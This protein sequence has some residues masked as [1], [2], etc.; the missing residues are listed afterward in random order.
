MKKFFSI[1]ML[2]VVAAGLAFAIGNNDDVQK[3]VYSGNGNENVGVCVNEFA[4]LRQLPENKNMKMQATPKTAEVTDWTEWTAYA[5]QD[6]PKGVYTYTAFF[7]GDD[8]LNIYVRESA[9]VPTTKQFKLEKWGMGIDLLINYDET[10]GQCRVPLQNI[11]YYHTTYKDSIYIGDF[12]YMISE[13]Y[14]DTYPCSYD[15]ETGLF[16]LNTFYTMKSYIGKGSGWYNSSKPETFKMSGDYVDY[17][18][19]AP[20]TLDINDTENLPEGAD[21]VGKFIIADAG[22]DIAYYRL[23]AFDAFE[24]D[25]EACKES[26]AVTFPTQFAP[27]DTATVTVTGTQ[28]VIYFVAYAYDSN[29][30]IVATTMTSSQLENN[31]D[32]E[33]V[34]VR[35]YRDD[36]LGPAYFNIST[37]EV[38]DVE[39][40][41]NIYYPSCYRLKNPYGSQTSFGANY[42]Q[43]ENAYMYFTIDSE[44][45]AVKL[46]KNIYTQDLGIDVMAKAYGLESSAPIS[47][48]GNS[49]SDGTFDGYAISWPVKGIIYG[50]GSSGYYGNTNGLERIVINFRETEVTAPVGVNVEE[51][52]KI[53]TNNSLNTPQFESLTPEVA[54]VDEKGNV[55]GVAAGTAQIKVTQEAILEYETLD[56]VLN[57]EVTKADYDIATYVFND[58]TALVALGIELPDSAAGASLN[59]K[60]LTVGDVSISFDKGEATTDPRIWHGASYDLRIYKKNSFTVSVPE[61]KK[62]VGIDVVGTKVSLLSTDVDSIVSQ[63]SNALTWEPRGAEYSSV[64][65]TT[66]GTQNITSITV[67]YAD[68]EPTSI[69]TAE[70]KKTVTSETYNLMGQKVAVMPKGIYIVNGKKVLY[71]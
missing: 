70:L 55:T 27:A 17:T 10:T 62:L 65:F 12:G 45:N 23:G 2:V 4:V 25:A 29:D 30:S 39:V 3:L 5:L 61:G 63:A 53:T 51:S 13:S 44:T 48:W 26:I 40:Q 41:R 69:G 11:G 19:S 47:I 46:Y 20:Y 16:T 66:T 43:Y 36:I 64:V 71:K 9:S 34:G 14:L 7:S 42:Y 50:A 54:T 24:Y 33:T 15:T 28:G 68:S 18:F 58:S 52:E 32:W 35:P 60:T 37:G 49:C 38:Y 1:M 21:A 6:E 22:K 56:T 31:A 59:G 8:T 67:R 57:I